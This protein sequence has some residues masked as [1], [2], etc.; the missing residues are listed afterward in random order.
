[1]LQ[2]EVEHLW[3]EI[4]KSCNVEI[5]WGYVL[6]IFQREQESHIYERICARHSAV[7]SPEQARFRAI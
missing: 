3:D 2:F 5:L 7:S 6:S 4:A 1:M